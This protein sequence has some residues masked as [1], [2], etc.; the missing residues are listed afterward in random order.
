M[1]GESLAIFREILAWLPYWLPVEAHVKNVVHFTLF[2]KTFI[3]ESTSSGFTWEWFFTVQPFEMV[4]LPI[5]T[6]SIR[7]TCVDN[8]AAIFVCN[9]IYRW[10]NPKLAVLT[11]GYVHSDDYLTIKLSKTARLEVS[12][13]RFEELQ[14]NAKAISDAII[15]NFNRELA[16]LIEIV[17]L[18]VGGYAKIYPKQLLIEGIQQK[19]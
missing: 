6:E 18:D 12:K 2:W 17:T 1:I 13:Y 19:E 16:G 15:D 5:E 4:E 8:S 10:I 14:E 3:Y 9:G 7:T 11:F